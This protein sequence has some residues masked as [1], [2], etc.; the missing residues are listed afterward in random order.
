LLH[1]YLT[2]RRCI[3][4]TFLGV[5]G[6]RRRL[7]WSFAYVRF[8]GNVRRGLACAL[9]HIVGLGSS[10]GRHLARF[11]RL[12]RICLRGLVGLGSSVGRHLARFIRLLRICLRG[13]VGLGNFRLRLWLDHVCLDATTPSLPWLGSGLLEHGLNRRRRV[14]AASSAPALDLGEHFGLLA[15]RNRRFFIRHGKAHLAEQADERS[16]FDPEFLR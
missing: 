16:A 13:L 4:D 12:L 9:R 3:V 6:V 10:V 2:V 14:G 7:G 11:I 1:R 8:R 15:S 5:G